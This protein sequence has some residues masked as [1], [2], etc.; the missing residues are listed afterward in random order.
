M[1]A[2]VTVFAVQEKREEWKKFAQISDMRHLVFLDESGVNTNL[3]RRY[4]RSIGKERV[5]DCSPLNTPQTTTILSSIRSDGSKETVT[6]FGGTTGTRFTE[7]LRTTLLPKLQPEDIVVMDNL[8]SH[9][10]KAV[11]EL[12]AGNKH[13]L[14]YLPPYSPDLN[15]IEKMWSK[16]KSILRKWKIRDASALPDAIHKALNLVTPD[17]CLHWFQSCG[18]C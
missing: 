2:N 8:R 15:P 13:Q 12:F 14:V 3:T 1:Q 18:Y 16:M 4:G 9:H 5:E 6:Y 10:V 7:Y 17:D 11:Q